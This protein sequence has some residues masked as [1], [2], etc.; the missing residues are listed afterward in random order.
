MLPEQVAQAM[1]KTMHE[2]GCSRSRAALYIVPRNNRLHYIDNLYA[3]CTGLLKRCGS[4]DAGAAQFL[5]GD[6]EIHRMS[7]KKTK[8][9]APG[10]DVR[11]TSLVRFPDVGS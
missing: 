8:P 3:S 2:Q 11:N 1:S 10:S 6:A 9:L 4:K 7:A 5:A